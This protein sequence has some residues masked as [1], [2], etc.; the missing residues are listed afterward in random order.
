MLSSATLLLLCSEA[1]DIS[2]QRATIFMLVVSGSTVEI[3][4][5]MAA[6]PRDARLCSSVD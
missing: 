5:R 3:D 1:E 2:P 4:V 6:N